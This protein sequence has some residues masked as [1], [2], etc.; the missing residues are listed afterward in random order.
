MRYPVSEAAQN[1]IRAKIRQLEHDQLY[2]LI[3][4]HTY[5][6]KRRRFIRMALGAPASPAMQFEG[7]VESASR[8][9][10]QIAGDE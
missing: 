3:D 7:L 8:L 2:G 1:E 10:R 4:Q 5:L 6:I 9:S